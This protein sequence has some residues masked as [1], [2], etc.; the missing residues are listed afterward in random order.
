[1]VSL[2]LGIG[3]I[4]ILIGT[5]VLYSEI[6]EPTDPSQILTGIGV[7]CIVL[8]SACIILIYWVGNIEIHQNALKTY[9][10]FG[11]ELKRYALNEFDSW[12]ESIGVDDFKDVRNI[13]LIK[14]RKKV[15]ISNVSVNEADYQLFKNSIVQSVTENPNLESA[16]VSRIKKIGEIVLA[17]LGL[18]ALYGSVHLY[19]NRDVSVSESNFK[20]VTGIVSFVE[21]DNTGDNEHIYIELKDYP[22]IRFKIGSVVI[23]KT[24]PGYIKKFMHVGETVSIGISTSDAAYLQAASSKKEFVSICTLQDTKYQLLSLEDYNRA[25]ASNNSLGIIG[26]ASMGFGWLFLAYNSVNKRR[27][28]SLLVGKSKN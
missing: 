8:G 25:V 2:L 27:A 21:V 17:L 26:L 3:L 20:I 5:A 11:Q 10:Y 13:T 14:G 16:R 4:W 9:S 24:Y 28:G 19:I 12:Y 6:M 23:D 18:F 1:M 7:T 22:L 15:Q